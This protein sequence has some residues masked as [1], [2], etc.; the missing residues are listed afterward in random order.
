M[1]QTPKEH[2]V[3]I[4]GLAGHRAVMWPLARHLHR[5]G[6]QTSRFGYRSFFHSIEAHAN[7][8]ADKLAELE[9]SSDVDS[10][11]LVAH[12][13]GSIVARQAIL[14]RPSEKLRRIVML[15]PPNQ[16]TP[17]ATLLGYIFPFS[18]TIHQVNHRK[19]SFVNEL[20][21]PVDVEIGIVAG[22]YDLVVPGPNSHLPTETDH[23]TIF[24]GHSGL[25]VRPAAARRVVEFLKNGRFQI[26]R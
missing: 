13:M 7:R 18:R 20:D 16:G 21:D 2:V 1:N 26:D 15:A 19:S 25:L 9:A 4:H 12:S 10:F 11:H 23:T 14:T 17:A 3:L 24:S 6:F 22:R 5:A 8:L